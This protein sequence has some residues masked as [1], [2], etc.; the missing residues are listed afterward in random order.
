MAE[1]KILRGTPV[2]LMQPLLDVLE[3]LGLSHVI[4]DN[5]AVRSA[6]VAA[7]DR[8]KPFLASSVPDLQLDCLGVQ[9]D[10]ADFLWPWQG[11]SIMCRLHRRRW[12]HTHACAQ[13]G[14]A[15]SWLVKATLMCVGAGAA[16]SD[17]P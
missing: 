9:L 8:A 6:V 2:N 7:G 12:S 3:G 16:G 1:A 5:D 17:E 10:G 11:A 14:E 15:R 13:T 4:H